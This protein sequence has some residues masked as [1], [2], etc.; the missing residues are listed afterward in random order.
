[1]KEPGN[2]WQSFRT[3]NI[4]GS[5]KYSIRTHE[6]YNISESKE[7]CHKTCLYSHLNDVLSSFSSP[8]KSDLL[9]IIF[10]MTSSVAT[11]P[12]FLLY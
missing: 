7:G 11:N 10:E 4:C 3:V 8:R 12:V 6:K 1:M 9:R 5:P 2:Y